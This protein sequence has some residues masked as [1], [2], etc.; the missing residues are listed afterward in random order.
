MLQFKTSGTSCHVDA[1]NFASIIPLIQSTP[2]A[3]IPLHYKRAE[4]TSDKLPALGGLTLV[5]WETHSDLICEKSK[6]N[7]WFGLNACSQGKGKTAHKLRYQLRTLPQIKHLNAVCI[8]LDVGRPDGPP[9]AQMSQ[10]EALQAVCDAVIDGIVPT[11]T[12][13]V[14]SGR[15]LYIVWMLHDENDPS[16]KPKATDETRTSYGKVSEKLTAMFGHLA[17]DKANN[18]ATRLLRVPGSINTKNDQRVMWH[19]WP[20]EAGQLASYSL[21]E[22]AEGLGIRAQPAAPAE[23]KRI[24]PETPKGQRRYYGKPIINR[25]SA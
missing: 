5:E 7:L 15:G 9:E 16:K 3:I 1:N 4:D 17:A 10:Q 8:D 14:Y 6:E 25:G 18:N 12:F 20:N 22:L 24:Y 21:E 13:Y 11:P 2:G 19:I 23:P